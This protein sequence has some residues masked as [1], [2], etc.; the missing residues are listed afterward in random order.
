MV[1]AQQTVLS[2][3]QAPTVSAPSENFTVAGATEKVFN[4]VTHVLVLHRDAY[5]S[6]VGR[7]QRMKAAFHSYAT[8][9]LISLELGDIA[10]NLFE[11]ARAD[12]DRFVRASCPEAAE[13]LVAVNERL[14]ENNRESRAAAL[15]SCRR[16]INSI[17]DSLFPPSDEPYLDG[18]GKKRDVGSEAYKNRLVAFVEQR[19]ESQS[20]KRILSS[21]LDHLVERLNSLYEKAC[22]G[23]HDDVSE[24]EAELVILQAYL[25]LGEQVQLAS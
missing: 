19:L 6:S 25:F 22:K 5:T 7:F 23:V 17:A 15:T 21:E 11:R 14:R 2:R 16:L 20:S 24:R 8:D 18:K 12:I 13:Q 3:L 1:T 4:H 10:E 9:T